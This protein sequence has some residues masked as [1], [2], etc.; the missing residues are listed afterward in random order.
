MM[1]K[2]IALWIFGFLTGG[3]WAQE[4]QYFHT[5]GSGASE[6]K[7]AALQELVSQ[8]TVAQAAAWSS[9]ARVQELAGLSQAI[10]ILLYDGL[11]LVRYRGALITEGAIDE[12]AIERAVYFFNVTPQEAKAWLLASR[13]MQMANF[14]DDGAALAALEHDLIATAGDLY[15]RLATY[16]GPHRALSCMPRLAHLWTYQP[17]VAVAQRA[18]PAIQ[19]SVPERRFAPSAPTVPAG[20]T[21]IRMPR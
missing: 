19:T 12:R 6:F 3:A 5:F 21:I 1:K 18:P 9:D 14:K 17:A 11:R 2:L 20:Y 13:L 15:L 10:D 16:V 4:P 8:D 7:I